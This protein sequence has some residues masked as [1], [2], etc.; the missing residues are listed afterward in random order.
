MKKLIRPLSEEFLYGSPE[1]MPSGCYQLILPG[2]FEMAKSG[3][4][5]KKER[6]DAVR[7]K[8]K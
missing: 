5:E 3:N 1:A 4:K 8:S 6:D 2:D 7:N